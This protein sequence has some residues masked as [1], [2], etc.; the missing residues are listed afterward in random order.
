[1]SI[2]PVFGAISCVAATLACLAL[3]GCGGDAGSDPPPALSIPAVE[4]AGSWDDSLSG[5][6]NSDAIRS[7]LNE[8]RPT[9]P[10]RPNKFPTVLVRTSVGE[11]T[12]RLNAEMAPA[13]V[14]NFLE[15]YVAREFYEG[16]IFH[17]VEDG[18]IAIGGGYTP[19]MELKETVT[20]V[21]NEASNGLKN[22]RGTIGM[23]RQYDYVD[24]ATSQF[25][26]NLA[27]N[28][29]LDHVPDG[30]DEKYGYCVFGEVVDGVEVLDAVARAGTRQQ[31]N[32]AFLPTE[33][34]VI[35]SIER[36]K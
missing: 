14:D 15:N 24:S 34:I 17:H 20:P 29:S 4:S 8:N 28:P 35:H 21:R 11:L 32:F 22:V 9:A 16:T 1:M 13:T 3:L 31:G 7:D 12:V 33:P 19:E 26:F 23:S 10:P 25:Y 18:F 27:D 30:D 36:L 6:A 5:L 2:R